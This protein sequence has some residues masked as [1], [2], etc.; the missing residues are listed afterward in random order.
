MIKVAIVGAT[1]Y[2]GQEL[3]KLLLRHPKVEIT[4]LVSQSNKNKS[5]GEAFPY[6]KNLID[7][8]FVS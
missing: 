4:Q 6:F 2:G 3:I 5:I 7:Q 1:G 8:K